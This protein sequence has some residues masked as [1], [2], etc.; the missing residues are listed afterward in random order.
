VQSGSFP[1]ELVPIRSLV[2]QFLED[3]EAGTIADDLGGFEMTLLHYRR[4][5]VEKMFAVHGK[6]MRFLDDG[7]PLGRDARHY[8]DLYYLA[9]ERE[10]QAMLASPEY[11]E[12][13]RDYDEKSRKF[14]PRSYRP[15]DGLSFSSSPALFPQ[16][17]LRA[18]LASG[19]ETEC[20][21]LF[22]AGGYPTFDEVLLRFEQLRSLL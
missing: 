11:G 18:Q 1:T 15:P 22:S 9:G 6:V 14:F 4:T 21:R 2:A 17:A 10:V 12:I 13:R 5:F 3:Q 19:Y 7:V 16:G 20:E 8:P